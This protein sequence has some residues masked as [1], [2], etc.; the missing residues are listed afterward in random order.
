MTK[1]IVCIKETDNSVE[2]KLLKKQW[3]FTTEIAK[4][5]TEYRNIGSA[6]FWEMIEAEIRYMTI[7]LNGNPYNA[8]DVDFRFNVPCYCSYVQR[9]LKD[10]KITA[11][12]AAEFNFWD[13]VKAMLFGFGYV[14]PEEKTYPWSVSIQLDTNH[15]HVE[16]WKIWE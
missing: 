7:H 2:M 4:R 1:L 3:M 9:A 12:N 11:V 16:G 5:V 14:S 13:E 6:E 10:F 8:V 15:K